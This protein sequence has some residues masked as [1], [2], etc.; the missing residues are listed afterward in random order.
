MILFSSSGSAVP[1]LAPP[2]F[3]YCA[4]PLHLDFFLSPLLRRSTHWQACLLPTNMTIPLPLSATCG[5]EAALLRSRPLLPS[6]PKWSTTSE[7]EK[8]HCRPPRHFSPGATRTTLS[9]KCTTRTK[10]KAVC[11]R[12]HGPQLGVH[13]CPLDGHG[14]QL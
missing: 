1:P 4:C 9:P 10:R 7:L 11:H 12:I 14:C 3:F 13:Q 6:S 8:S 5:D 2:S